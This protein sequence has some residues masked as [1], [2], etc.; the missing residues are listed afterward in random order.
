MCINFNG[1][2]SGG[3]SFVNVNECWFLQKSFVHYIYKFSSEKKNNNKKSQY[4]VSH[5]KTGSDSPIGS[6]QESGLDTGS[7]KKETLC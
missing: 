3:S 1:Y 4:I 6:D 2:H 5:P 7:P